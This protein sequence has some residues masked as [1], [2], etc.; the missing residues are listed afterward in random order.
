MAISTSNFP[1]L[2]WPGIKSIFG[3]SYKDWP[4]LYSQVYNIESSTLAFEKVQGVTGFGLAGKKTPGANIPYTQPAQGFQ[5]EYVN[6]TYGIGAIVTREMY[7][8][9]QYRYINQL[10]RLLARSMRQTEETV[11]WNVVNRAFNTNY[12]GADGLC[13]CNSAHK[14]VLG[15]TYS[16]V[17]ATA[18]DLTQT[19][20]ETAIMQVSDMVDDQGLKIMAHPVKLVIPTGLVM[21]AK[22]ILN[23]TQVT[24]SA[25]NDINPIKGSL[26]LVVSPY[27]TD[28]DAWFLTTDVPNGLTWFW[29]RRTETTRDGD[30]D[31]QVLKFATSA[32][33]V[34][35]WTDPRA[36]LGTPGV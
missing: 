16:N 12:T 36:I 33:Y 3:I 22:K 34:C 31:T 30:H 14:L 11:A 35:G 24:G 8:D 29:R 5:K 4:S 32:R 1:E 17:L 19:A 18:S 10:P 23:S 15:G 26:Q 7:E 28:T 2:L 25:D 9:D 20:L 21:T 6:E 13:L 27:L